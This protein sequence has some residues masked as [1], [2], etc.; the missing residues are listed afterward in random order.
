MNELLEL[1]DKA[2]GDESG[3]LSKL[4]S[5]EFDPVADVLGIP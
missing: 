1:L 5:G 3:F 2:R 4:R